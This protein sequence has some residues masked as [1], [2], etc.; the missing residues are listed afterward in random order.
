MWDLINIETKMFNMV[1]RKLMEVY[2]TIHLQVH[3]LMRQIKILSISR[4]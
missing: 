4:S 2:Q 1:K 3:K